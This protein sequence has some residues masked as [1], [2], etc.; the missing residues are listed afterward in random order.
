MAS[1]VSD[2]IEALLDLLR[3]EPPCEEVTTAIRKVEVAKAHIANR[4]SRTKTARTKRT[5]KK[6]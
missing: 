4:D 1:E 5:K 3:S 2:K 6:S